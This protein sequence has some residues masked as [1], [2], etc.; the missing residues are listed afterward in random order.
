MIVGILGVLF[1]FVMA[2][3][4]AR[5]ITEPLNSLLQGVQEIGKG[6]LNARCP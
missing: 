1:A 3:F 5:R 2:L 6:N 4:I